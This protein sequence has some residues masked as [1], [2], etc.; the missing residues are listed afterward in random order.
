[1]EIKMEILAIEEYVP[2][3]KE[4]NAIELLRDV[5]SDQLKKIDNFEEAK[6]LFLF[7]MITE[8]DSQ[9]LSEYINTMEKSG[10]QFTDEFNLFKSAWMKDEWNHYVGYRRLYSLSSSIDENDLHQDVIN[11][12]YDFTPISHML[13]DEFQLCLVLAY[14]ELFTTLSCKQDM[15]LYRSFGISSLA[16]WNKLVARDEAY[17]FKN[18]IDVITRRHKNRISDAAKVLDEFIEWDMSGNKYEN[19]FVLD[20]DESRYSKEYLTNIRDKIISQLKRESN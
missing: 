14:D 13:S 9:H 15:P 19:T 2:R 4:W 17:H 18:I 10:M 12:E 8:Y 5:T 11:R 20:H 16:K 1:M 6:E 7:D 3:H